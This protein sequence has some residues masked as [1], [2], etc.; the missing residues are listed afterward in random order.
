LA[1][2]AESRRKD[3]NAAVQLRAPGYDRESAEPLYESQWAR[4]LAPA[5]RRLL[6]LASIRPGEHV[7]DVACG[8]GSVTIPAAWGVGSEGRVL[9]TDVSEAMVRRTAAEAWEEGI[10]WIETRRAGPEDRVGP[11]GSFDAAIC[12]FGLTRATDPARALAAMNRA[13]RPG[14]RV[15]VTVWGDQERC[16]WAE[17]DSIVERRTRASRHFSDFR[18]GPGDTLPESL[19]L[20]GFDVDMTE[21]IGMN[22]GYPSAAAASAAVL[23][24]GRLAVAFARLD[25]ATRIRARAEYLASIAAH[26]HG[27]GY[28]VPGEFVI[29]RAI[30]PAA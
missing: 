9:A 27:V 30:K 11:D 21:R 22:L 23:E 19:R 24:G 17:A 6:E 14:G 3:V 10:G 28:E 13:L 8:V 18:L 20:A 12:A 25:A 7:L 4:H 16:G 2:S 1:V 26:R 29:A 5:Q 15:V